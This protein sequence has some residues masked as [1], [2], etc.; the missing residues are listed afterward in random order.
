MESLKLDQWH[1][2]LQQTYGVPFTDDAV[3]ILWRA[4]KQV[5]ELSQHSELQFPVRTLDAFIQLTEPNAPLGN[6]K[7]RAPRE[8]FNAMSKHEE[9]EVATTTVEAFR[10]SLEL[11]ACLQHAAD[12][13]I[14]VGTVS[15]EERGTGQ[16]SAWHIAYA[17]LTADIPVIAAFLKNCNS[18]LDQASYQFL[19]DFVK[20][21]PH[22]YEQADWTQELKISSS[23]TGKSKM[24]V[25]AIPKRLDKL[26]DKFLAQ[27]RFEHNFQKV[28]E[29]IRQLQIQ[30]VSDLNQRNGYTATENI[31]FQVTKETILYGLLLTVIEQKDVAR[32]LVSPIHLQWAKRVFSKTNTNAKDLNQLLIQSMQAPFYQ[33]STVEDGL[34]L[35]SAEMISFFQTVKRTADELSHSLEISERHFIAIWLG[36]KHGKIKARGIDGDIAHL[37]YTCLREHVDQDHEVRLDDKETWKTI[38]NDIEA[39]LDQNKDD[40]AEGLSSGSGTDFRRNSHPEELGGSTKD[41]AAAV[42]DAFR[43][44]DDDDFCFALFGP[45]G[46]GKTTLMDLVADQLKDKFTTVKFNAWRYP[47]RP[48]IW[49]SLYETICEKAGGKSWWNRAKLALQTN[50]KKDSGFPLLIAGV[51]MLFAAIPKGTLLESVFA[52]NKI[53]GAITA[54]IIGSYALRLWN[55]A[56]QTLKTYLFLPSHKGHLGLQ[57]VIGDDLKHL[58]QTWT[59]PALDNSWDRIKKQW[60]YS[61]ACITIILSLIVMQGRFFSDFSIAVKFLFPLLTIAFSVGLFKLLDPIEKTEKVLLVVDDLDRCPSE[62]IL[63]VIESL[64][65]LLDDNDKVDISKCL[66]ISMLIDR[67]ILGHAIA[68]KYKRLVDIGDSSFE[69]KAAI[70]P[71]CPKQLTLEQIEKLFLLTFEIPPLSKDELQSIAEKITAFEATT[72]DSDTE[73]SKDEDITIN[74][75]EDNRQAPSQKKQENA[76][77]EELSGNDDQAAFEK[78]NE[79][80]STQ[81]GVTDKDLN[82]PEDDIARESTETKAA[83]FTLSKGEKE[84][85]VETFKQLHI[86]EGDALT[87]RRMRMFTMRFYLARDLCERLQ[88]MRPPA[89]LI[90]LLR[91]G[92]LSQTN[93]EK[94][95]HIIRMVQITSPTELTNSS[96]EA[97]KP[98]P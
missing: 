60:A 6:L 51:S 94:L 96:S 57:S 28:L 40:H 45:W 68:Q 52:V 32:S 43:Q 69:K 84:L 74:R 42:A 49:V 1:N 65:V 14:S 31:P 80:S 85:L 22:L 38:F 98:K 86:D 87:P 48:E 41:Y 46:S 81:A 24:K 71:F 21:R 47:T 12:R 44:S 79:Q 63:P 64:R 13:A 83:Q 15:N 75:V 89:E 11:H 77:K 91:S 27:F 72:E 70:L 58:L 8:T 56:G 19:G 37:C 23:L 34:R 29:R 97:K 33:A 93:D 39:N 10:P 61:A 62:E 76:E 7:L 16:V 90:K 53:S 88:C 92:D 55:G 4:S 66:K 17:L 2:G 95:K 67:R 25:D 35:M 78:A 9:S 82:T 50:L 3:K 73:N 26:W 54:V 18:S 20:A 5:A 59:E 30:S 36:G